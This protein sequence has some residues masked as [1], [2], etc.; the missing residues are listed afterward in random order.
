[1]K[2]Y[3]RISILFPIILAFIFIALLTFA[4]DRAG[5]KLTYIERSS[6]ND[7]RIIGGEDLS[8][9]DFMIELELP[10][11][12]FYGV[13]LT[14]NELAEGVE[15]KAEIY[16]KNG[17]K[18]YPLVAK[19][20]MEGEQ[21][22]LVCNLPKGM[23]VE[24]DGE[25]IFKLEKVE[26]GKEDQTSE[27]ISFS[28]IEILGGEKDPWWQ[29]LY[30]FM[31]IIVI[32]YSLLLI[33]LLIIGKKATLQS[34][35]QAGMLAVLVF[36]LLLIYRSGNL[37]IFT[38]ENDNLR[39]GIIIAGGGVL[40]RDYYTQHTPLMYY[41][42]SVFA[43]LGAKSVEQFRILYDLFIALIWVL[44][45]FRN[46]KIFGNKLMIILPLFETI[47]VTA[48]YPQGAMIMADNV[49][50]ICTVVLLLEFLRY[51][52]NKKIDVADSCVIS[53]TLWCSIGAAFI[54]AYSI[55]T[56]VAGVIFSEILYWKEKR[57]ISFNS[58][59]KR[60][61]KLLLCCIIPGGIIFCYFGIKKNIGNLYLQAFK[62][63]T[64]VYPNYYLDGFGKNKIEPFILSVKN[65]GLYIKERIIEL[66]GFYI[67]YDN[68]MRLSLCLLF[69]YLLIMLVVKRKN[70][71][72]A[73]IIFLAV[74]CNASRGINNFHSL[75]FWY[76]I[77]AAIL[78]ILLLNYK[79]LFTGKRFSLLIFLLLMCCYPYIADFKDSINVSPQPVSLTEGRVVA[80]TQ[81]GDSIFL[82]ANACDSLYL[83]YKDRFPVNRT[84]Y[85]LPWY[86]DW[87]EEDTLEDIDSKKP[88]VAVWSI[89]REVW[90][91]TQYGTE[92]DVYIRENYVKYLDDDIVWVRKND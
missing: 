86:M 81:K 87:F 67:T 14:F 79:S 71:L 13:R 90:G 60:Y 51:R 73:G 65:F 9:D 72:E 8:D 35:V 54:S 34:A 50:G 46:H 28:E 75:P 66:S 30:T 42:C 25:Y 24:A 84:S 39:G 40:Y 64:D 47:I 41:I 6:V 91:I 45:Y 78:F 33:F 68:I 16:E 63:N 2:R 36:F 18:A 38:D 31:I 32:V 69:V 83:L 55:F 3:L 57:K 43:Y 26:T 1:M 20:E 77:I 53:L 37:A 7:Y 44:L 88:E 22:V 61:W 21:V 48:M 74:C 19:L 59:L 27:N 89:D 70:Y 85:I 29:N 62:F 52:I 56:V 12:L 15:Y 11:E 5:N 58:C 17:G 4:R 80:L 76:A 49:Q 92:I 10:Y 23:N 82:D